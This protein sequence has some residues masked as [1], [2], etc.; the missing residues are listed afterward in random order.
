MGEKEGNLELV[1]QESEKNVQVKRLS[2]SASVLM[3]NTPTNTKYLP[4]RATRVPPFQSPPSIVHASC[5]PSVI[6]NVQKHTHLTP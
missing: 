3:E 6:S 1:S 4:S 2:T 5:V